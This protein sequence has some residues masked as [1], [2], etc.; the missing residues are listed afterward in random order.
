MLCYQL[1]WV[2]NDIFAGF[3]YLA[4]L[5]ADS[6]FFVSIPDNEF[7]PIVTIQDEIYDSR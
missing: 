7:K 4:N 6:L 5:L 1:V 2:Q 3:I